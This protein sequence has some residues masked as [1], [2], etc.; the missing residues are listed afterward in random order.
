MNISTD[1]PVPRDSIQEIFITSSST[2]GRVKIQYNSPLNYTEIIRLNYTNEWKYARRI[3]P[4]DLASQ[5][6]TRLNI[7]IVISASMDISVQANK[8]ETGTGDGYLAL[9]IT[10]Q[11][12]QFFL[13]S[14]SQTPSMDQLFSII[15]P[16]NDTC[17]AV[18]YV[19]GSTGYRLMHL[20]LQEN[21]VYHAGSLDFDYTGVFITSSRPV[22]VYSGH[23]CAMVPAG[24]LYCD[25]L[26]EQMPPIS[27]WG[28]SFIVSSFWGR[29]WATGFRI[30]V[31]A[32]K[33]INVSFTYHTYN[34]SNNPVSSNVLP[35][36]SIIRGQWYETAFENVTTS[37]AIVV[38]I[39]CS[40]NCLVMQYATGFQ[41]LSPDAP[42]EV[43]L[44][45]P[46]MVTALP[47]DHYQNN[48]RFSTSRH[49]ANGSDYE[50]A[51]GITIVAK[52]SDLGKIYVDG[53]PV[54]NLGGTQY[55]ITAIDWS[56]YAVVIAPLTVGFHSVTSQDPNII[57]AVYVYGYGIK[58]HTGYG[59]LGGYRY[60][61]G[62]NDQ[63]ES[64]TY[65]LFNFALP[66][67]A[68]TPSPTLPPRT[69]SPVIFSDT[70]APF[71][72]LRYTGRYYAFNLE[73][74]LITKFCSD[75][76]SR[77]FREKRLEAMKVKVTQYMSNYCSRP[78][79][80]VTA[81]MDS[82]IYSEY[83]AGVI[84][85]SVRVKGSGGS[86]LRD[87]I[88]CAKTSGLLD[89]FENLANWVDRYNNSRDVLK[90][91]T[92]YTKDC[93][94]VH[95]LPEKFTSDGYGWS[96]PMAAQDLFSSSSVSRLSLFVA[97]VALVAFQW[98]WLS[99]KYS[100]Q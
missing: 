71:Y 29:P 44:P 72:I 36:V 58:D 69:G 65:P 77:Y 50:C 86:T 48:I 100:R 49:F 67:A 31:I 33:Q 34:S 45:D 47:L 37:N 70:D 3:I 97:L 98:H 20:T 6:N 19:N 25:H 30:R 78:G 2:D 24:R 60:L 93:S 62:S 95:F 42:G 40:D 38:M 81:S 64:E 32:Q 79:A 55:N 84:E 94:V 23:A 39:N 41:I 89:H 15:S 22:A 63:P 46:F 11:S 27:Q 14:Y 16:F 92:V 28:K 66:S 8:A 56:D 87:I 74:N 90:N 88:S 85:I 13:A 99:G 61:Y 53:Y 82:F 96:C 1:S 52:Q 83:T 35:T 5:L 59:Y 17:I 73:G 68:A 54:V 7:A 75:G 18:S 43:Y 12:R 10:A 57:Y 4:R 91:D 80:S 26:V 9:P 21:D 76:Y 51:N